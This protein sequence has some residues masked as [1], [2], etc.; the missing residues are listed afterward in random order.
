MGPGV[1]RVGNQR[2]NRADIHRE[3]HFDLVLA[4]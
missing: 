2:G 3:F 1:A 4:C